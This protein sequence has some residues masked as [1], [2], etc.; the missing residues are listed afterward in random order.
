MNIVRLDKTATDGI[1][2][3]EQQCFSTPWSSE[4]VLSTISNPNNVFIGAYLDDTLVGYGSFNTVMDEGYINNIA[5]LPKYR[6]QGIA[7]K[8]LDDMIA[9]AKSLNLSF[10]T[11]EVRKSNLTAISLYEGRGFKSVGI[12]KNFYTAPL[13]DGVIMT[14]YGE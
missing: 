11:L 13:E 12:R 8:I 1:C 7:G 5:V 6:R 3:I 10:L 2:N 9:T 4:S 14:L